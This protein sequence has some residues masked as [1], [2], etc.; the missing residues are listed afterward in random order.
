MA[1]GTD[2]VREQAIDAAM[3]VFERNLRLMAP[4]RAFV[5]EALD[6]AAEVYAA[7]DAAEVDRV[8][9]ETGLIGMEP[10][11]DGVRIRLKHAADLAAGMVAAF[12]ELIRQ[13]GCEN[14]V[15][16][17]ST[18]TDPTDL[19]KYTFIV[20]KPG[21][22]TPHELRRQAEQERDE[23]R[24]RLAALTDGSQRTA[25]A[26][27]TGIAAGWCPVHGTCTCPPGEDGLPWRDLNHPSC[28][29]HSPESSHAE[30][31]DRG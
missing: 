6:A 28:P 18:V 20:V 14:Y 8:L 22:K 12:D 27:C 1:D 9:A 5:A 23:L 25:A 15:E 26:E 7:A 21:G 24:A 30:E 13:K 10:L 2:P 11:A 3:A 31:A 16:W 29:L 4:N 19:R 17:D